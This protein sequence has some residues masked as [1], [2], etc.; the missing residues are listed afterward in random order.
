VVAFFKTP[1]GLAKEVAVAVSQWERDAGRETAGSAAGA[2]SYSAT[3]QGDGAI[4]QGPGAVAV[5]KGGVAIRGNVNG[6]VIVTGDGNVVG[7][8]SEG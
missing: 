5:G 6:S 8:K 3:L 2:T 7:K 4:A 1:E